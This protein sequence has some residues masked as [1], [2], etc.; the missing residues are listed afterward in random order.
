MLF[1]IHK[2]QEQPAGNRSPL[3]R[4]QLAQVWIRSACVEPFLFFFPGCSLFCEALRTASLQVLG[5]AETS[6]RSA[7][8]R[9]HSPPEKQHQNKTLDA[10]DPC[11]C[12]K[13]SGTRHG[14]WS[15]LP[16]KCR[17]SRWGPRSKP[18]THTWSLEVACKVTGAITVCDGRPVWSYAVLRLWRPLW[19]IFKHVQFLRL[20]MPRQSYS[21]VSWKLPAST[22]KFE[23]GSEL[24]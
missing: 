19:W 6:R 13:Y 12:E 11:K 16:L 8:L 10:C 24:R 18:P 3:V 1:D 15:V 22:F 20:D 5:A 23:R 21:A 2:P 7:S 14:L 17:S 9:W 4:T